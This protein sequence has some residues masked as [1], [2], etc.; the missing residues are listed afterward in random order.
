MPAATASM[1]WPILRARSSR[2]VASSSPN[3]QPRG[4]VATT[5]EGS[6]TLSRRSAAPVRDARPTA[7]LR[8]SPASGPAV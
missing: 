8:A 2:L 6:T 5:V 4:S 1:A 7:A 3:P